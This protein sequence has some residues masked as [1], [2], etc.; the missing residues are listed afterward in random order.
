MFGCC[1]LILYLLAKPSKGI[2]KGLTSHIRYPTF[3]K[4]MTCSLG[5]EQDHL[6][7]QFDRDLNAKISSATGRMYTWCS[8]NLDF[9]LGA[10]KIVLLEFKEGLH[11][12]ILWDITTYPGEFLLNKVKH[13]SC[14]LFSTLFS[15]FHLCHVFW[16]ISLQG[17]VV[18]Q[19]WTKILRQ[20]QSMF[21]DPHTLSM[22]GTRAYPLLPSL[23]SLRVQSKAF[24]N[25]DLCLCQLY[26][27]VNSSHWCWCFSFE[28]WFASLFN[29]E[30]ALFDKSKLF[31]YCINISGENL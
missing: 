2:T 28:P 11:H 19:F 22:L 4:G 8:R 1:K 10:E 9:L 30:N 31:A 20:L 18:L 29:W 13:F 24:Q 14:W 16:L 26:S 25:L 17:S 27:T 5:Q 3:R 21:G 23:K 6:T 7:Q 15:Y 12:A